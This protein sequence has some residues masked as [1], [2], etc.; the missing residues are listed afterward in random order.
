M[1]NLIKERINLSICPICKEV[2][3]E[4]KIIKD[5]INGDVKIC[6]KHYVQGEI[7]EN[8]I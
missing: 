6:K 8:I 1:N 3:I 5:N 7:N 2:S 4:I